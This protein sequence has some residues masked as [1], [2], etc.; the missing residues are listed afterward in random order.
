MGNRNNKKKEPW[1]FIVGIISIAYIVCMWVKKDIIAT[2]TTMPQ[3]Q[4][5]PLIATTF[6][7]SLIKVAAIAGGIFMIKWF[8]GK[9]KKR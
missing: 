8:I 7:V 1:R 2:Y 9:V 5:I 3:E 4:V 6:V